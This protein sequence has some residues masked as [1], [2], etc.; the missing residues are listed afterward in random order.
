MNHSLSAVYVSLP[1]YKLLFLL[2]S[3]AGFLGLRPC[4]ILLGGTLC[5]SGWAI[6]H[7]AAGPTK[8]SHCLQPY[9]IAWQRTQI[10]LIDSSPSVS[11]SGQ[12]SGKT[13]WCFQNLVHQQVWVELLPT[14]TPLGGTVLF[15]P[16]TLMLSR[17]PQA[18]FIMDVK[19]SFL[20]APA[21][22]K[23]CT[24]MWS[25]VGFVLAWVSLS[26]DGAWALH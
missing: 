20:S 24:V 3:H 19:M 11:D 17:K 9:G 12:F 18:C 15:F 5:L 14:H 26:K 2:E 8:C 7:R 1:Q 16:L 21:L 25:R 4:M 10:L 6:V 22:Q 23:N 13:A